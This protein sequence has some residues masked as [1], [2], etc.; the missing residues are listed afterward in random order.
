MKNYGLIPQIDWMLRR[1][2]EEDNQ[3]P[4]EYLKELIIKKYYK[5]FREDE[6]QDSK[7]VGTK[8]WKSNQTTT[9]RNHQR[10]LCYLSTQQLFCLSREDQ[11]VKTKSLREPNL[12]SVTDE[13]KKFLQENSSQ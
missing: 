3:K 9:L 2:S 4:E 1:L 11:N 13:R 12:Q 7:Q 8:D 10:G 6:Y 5:E